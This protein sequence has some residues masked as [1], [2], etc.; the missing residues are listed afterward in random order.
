[1]PK[2]NVGDT[3]EYTDTDDVTY[4]ATILNTYTDDN[5][6]DMATLSLSGTERILKLENDFN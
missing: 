2:K 3:F 4:L 6:T 5:N 1:M